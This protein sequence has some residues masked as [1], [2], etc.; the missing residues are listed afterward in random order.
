[1]SQSYDFQNFEPET[2]GA[3]AAPLPRKSNSGRNLFLILFGG[4]GGLSVLA[5]CMCAGLVFYATRLPSVAAYGWGTGAQ[6]GTS[7]NLSRTYTCAN[8]QAEQ[9][10]DEYDTRGVAIEEFVP[11]V[12]DLGD[13]SATEITAN[14]VMRE[15]GRTSDWEATFVMVEGGGNSGLRYCIDEIRVI[16]STR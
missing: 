15:N 13:L 16:G 9:L 11:E 3:P 8:S 10:T 6:S 14:G 1:M 2:F 12:A 5:C 7:W 4:C